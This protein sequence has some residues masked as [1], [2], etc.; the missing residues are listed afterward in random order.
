M[1]VTQTHILICILL[2]LFHC[3]REDTT[4]LFTWERDG[5]LED[6][7]VS[8]GRSRQNL[9]WLFLLSSSTLICYLPDFACI[10]TSRAYWKTDSCQ[11]KKQFNSFTQLWCLETTKWSGWQDIFKGAIMALGTL[12]KTSLIELKIHTKGKNYAWQWSLT[13]IFWLERSWILEE[14]LLMSLPQTNIVPK[15]TI[16]IYTHR[17]V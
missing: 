9:V 7:T 5:Q 15:S 1:A 11:H 2:I 16:N 12:T 10:W 4:I 14:N 3:H 8:S 13:Q 17:K 6:H